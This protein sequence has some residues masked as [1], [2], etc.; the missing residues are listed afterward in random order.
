MSLDSCPQIEDNI[1]PYPITNSFNKTSSECFLLFN[2]LITE[3]AFTRRHFN[4]FLPKYLRC[5]CL[6]SYPNVMSYVL[7]QSQF[8]I[9]TFGF[10]TWG[11]YISVYIKMYIN[12]NSA[13]YPEI[14][15]RTRHFY[16]LL[17]KPEPKVKTCVNG[18]DFNLNVLCIWFPELL[19]E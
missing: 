15:L 19:I 2:P 9:A 1:L 12:Y 17:D 18:T 4:V 8:C 11:Q 6:I 3:T 16:T 7:A 13:V 5:S 14:L 10:V